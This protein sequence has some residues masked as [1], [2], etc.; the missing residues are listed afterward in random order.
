MDGIRKALAVAA[1]E[2]QV[3]SKDRAWLFTIF[4][5][6]LLVSL[7]VSSLNSGGG[8]FELPMIVVNHDAGHYGEDILNILR[9]IED[10]RLAEMAA[11][12]E[13]NALVSEG[14][15]LAA[16]IIPQ[17]FSQR[18]DAY[19]QT[20]VQV[21]LDPA[22][23]QFGTIITS[24]VD[25]V[26]TPVMMQGEI[27]YGI[28]AVQEKLGIS[29]ESDPA[30]A[31]AT[32]AQSEGVVSTQMQRIRD[33]PPV[34]LR[35]E[36]LEDASV[37]MPDNLLTVFM[38]GFT[39]LFAFF[40]M[41][42]LAQELLREKEG[43]TLRRLLAAPL[44]RSGII[45]G[46]MLAYM[47][48]IVLQVA[49]IFGVGAIIFKMPLGDSPLGL[50]LVTLALGLA[51]SSLGM[52]LAALARSA[53]QAD[54]VGVL[55]VFV[56]GGLGGCFMLGLKPLFRFDGPIG[57]ISNLTPHAHALEAYWR[58]MIEGGGVVD[59][60]PQIAVLLVMSLVFLLIAVWRFK[61]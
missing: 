42:A 28:R 19:E 22:Q 12:A 8:N 36:G 30:T 33:N 14:E 32:Q 35:T 43:G 55:L 20:K 21:V 53:K 50:L 49:F 39:V 38:P 45:S 59:V 9:D 2:L 13:A 7:I 54:N 31:Q 23:A 4:L 17:D 56:L 44:A 41:P 6:P 61:F 48:V 47:L 51:A 52:M 58:L 26:V 57:V 24:I 11:D 25:E 16:L 3:F 1:K 34:E 27:R 10:L 5:I 46:K 37:R 15:F 18:V 60:L 40:L 29:E